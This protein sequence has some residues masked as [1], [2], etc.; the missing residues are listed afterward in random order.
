M[1]DFPPPPTLE[2][3]YSSWSVYDTFDVP[4]GVTDPDLAYAKWNTDESTILFIFA[5]DNDIYPYTVATKTLGTALTAALVTNATVFP[6][7]PHWSI[8]GRYYLFWDVTGE[9]V[10]KIVKNGAVVQTVTEEN[11]GIVDLHGILGMSPSGKWIAVTGHT[12]AAD[13]K[14]V[15]LGGS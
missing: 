4:A 14:L 11:L 9:D 3:D 8:Q 10:L 1:P 5:Y 2:G 15:L 13:H 12:N 6:Q 7:W